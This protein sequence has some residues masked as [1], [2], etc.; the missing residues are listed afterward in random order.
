MTGSP[1]CNPFNDNGGLKMKIVVLQPT[2]L[3]QRM[4]Q[5]HR[6][7]ED[8]WIQALI[9]N[10]KASNMV[11]IPV[12]TSMPIVIRSYSR[13]FCQRGYATSKAKEENLPLGINAGSVLDHHTRDRSEA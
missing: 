6:N 4:H 2:D 8:S 1:H 10:V 11:G 9:I 5:T 12:S 7:M 3:V 13:R